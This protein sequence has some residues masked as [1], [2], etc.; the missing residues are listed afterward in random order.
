MQCNIKLYLM[1]LSVIDMSNLLRW[2]WEW[3]LM[4]PNIAEVG[5]HHDC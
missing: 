5:R 3:R 1:K 4:L 2:K